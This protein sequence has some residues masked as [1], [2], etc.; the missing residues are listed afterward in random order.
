MANGTDAADTCGDVRR[1]AMVATLE[2]GLEKAGRFIDVEL[3]V[4]YSIAV[5]LDI[6]RALTFHAREGF[7]FE[8]SICGHQSGFA[9]S[10]ELL[11]SRNSAE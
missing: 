6:Q 8:C 3:N 10:N 4:L 5:K 1:V 7:H 2:E 9:S 11:A